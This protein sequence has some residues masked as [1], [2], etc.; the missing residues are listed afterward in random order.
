MPGPT[1]SDPWGQ[2][3]DVDGTACYTTLGLDK[4]C[5]Q[6][7]VKKAYR[8]L[9]RTLHPDKGGR[10]EAFSALQHAF[11]VL[12]DPKRRAV[13][14]T[15]AAQ[16]QYRSVRIVA[17]QAGRGGE[18]I[19]LDE[20]DALGL[21]CE[22]AT[23]LVVT[24]EVCGRPATK[25]CWTCGMPICEFCTL[26][27]HWKDNFPLH[28]P[29]I[30]SDHMRERLARRELEKKRLEDASQAALEG[31]NHR[32]E[33]ELRDVRAFKAAAQAA[34]AGPDP[35]GTPVQGLTRFYMWAQTERAVLIAARVPT[36][37]ADRELVVEASAAG[38]LIQS[39]ESPALID[40]DWAFPVLAG[41]PVEVSRTVDNRFCTVSVT[42]AEYG[43]FWTRLF[44]GD[45]DGLRCLEPP[46]R[47]TDGP[48]DVVMEVTLPFWIEPADV[49]VVFSETGV[50]VMVRNTLHVSRTFWRN[51][52]E[53]G[54]R[55]AYAAVDV[56]ECLW[57]LDE[58]ELGGEAVRILMVT[59]ARPE[60]TEE[61]ITWKKGQRQDNRSKEHP[62]MLGRRGYRFFIEDEDE[63]ELEDMLQAACFAEAGRTFVPAKPW[64]AGA[65][66]RWV[67]AAQALPKTVQALLAQLPRPGPE[68]AGG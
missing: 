21:H 54:R 40:R 29:L 24:C 51:E 13:Y 61:E 65:Q 32:S 8:R 39:E 4:R 30:N 12:I 11:E 27:Q 17:Q 45:S 66:P 52:E 33:R 57:S 46:Y 67:D 47:L 14:D 42:K 15:W 68:P 26:K 48:D 59:L 23:Q 22:P 41:A 49:G 25:Q 6:E 37:Y 50:D 62:G 18:D 63:F 44:R 34:L 9:A 36:G 56:D 64:E 28:W 31:P 16:L 58:E 5:S 3:D 43:Q 53:A 2:L 19:L 38:L 1:P 35:R 7:D 55:R 10:P 20:F 60:L